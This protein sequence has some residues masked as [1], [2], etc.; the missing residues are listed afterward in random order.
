[1][2]AF[3]DLTKQVFGRLKVFGRI[4]TQKGHPV[5]DC[6]CSCGGRAEVTT[7]NLRSGRQISCGCAQ[8]TH[9]MTGTSEAQAFY[10]AKN[11][12]TNRN[13]KRFADY[14]GRGIKFLFTSF[15]QFLNHVGLKPSPELTLDRIDNDGNYEIGNVR[16]ATRAVQVANRRNMVAA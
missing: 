13:N 10:D 16:W 3:M 12:C 7:S 2:P 15:V 8:T 6:H 4:G 5:W 1:M 9:G 14:G 11:R